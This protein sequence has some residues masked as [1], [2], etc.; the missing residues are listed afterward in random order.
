VAIALDA[1]WSKRMLDDEPMTTSLLQ[2]LHQAADT[3]RSCEARLESSSHPDAKLVGKWL[4]DLG[5]TISNS[6]S[7]A[8]NKRALIDAVAE[9]VKSS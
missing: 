5:D 7:A 2:A 9:A 6:A 1:Y 8:S 4:R 3:C